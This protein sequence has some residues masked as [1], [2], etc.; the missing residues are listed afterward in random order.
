MNVKRR[1]AVQVNRALRGELTF[2]FA[3]RGTKKWGRRGGGE[4]ERRGGRLSAEEASESSG[5]K[6]F[7]VPVPQ[8]TSERLYFTF[9]AAL[10]HKSDSGIRFEV[11]FVVF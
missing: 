10:K 1:G 9:Y 7:K 8:M 3:V 2:G 5:K 4:E 11:F 6:H